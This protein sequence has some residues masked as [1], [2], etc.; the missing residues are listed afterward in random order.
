MDASIAE[1]S[2][3]KLNAERYTFLANQGAVSR[4]DQDFYV[5][6]A[7]ESHDRARAA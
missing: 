6:Q 7:I 4:K 2:K 1:A 5:S 3:D